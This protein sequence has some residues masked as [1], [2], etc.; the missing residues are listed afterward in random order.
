MN[1]RS[2]WLLV[3]V[4]SF[5]MV[6]SVIPAFAETLPELQDNE[7]SSESE[8][9]EYGKNDFNSTSFSEPDFSNNQQDE[10]KT[11]EESYI[12]EGDLDKS[13]DEEIDKSQRTTDESANDEPASNDESVSNEVKESPAISIVDEIGNENEFTAI[14]K[15]YSTDNKRVKAAVW[16]DINGQ[17]DLKWY[18]CEF[19]NDH[20]IA[21]IPVINHRA[22][23]KYYVHFYDENNMRF[24]AASE[25]NVSKPGCSR[26]TAE[27]IDKKTGSFDIIIENPESVSGIKNIRVAVWSS[28]DCSDLKWYNAAVENDNYRVKVNISDHEYNLRKY[29]AHIY[30]ES[31]NGILSFIGAVDNIDMSAEGTVEIKE[32]SDTYTINIKEIAALNNDIDSIKC[33]VW[34]NINGQDD[35]KWVEGSFEVSSDSASISYK[36]SMFKDFGGYSVHV[37][38]KTKTGKMFFIKALQYEIEMPVVESID[39]NVTMDTGS[40]SIKLT[41]LSNDNNIK[42]ILVPVWSKPD[43]SNIIWYK[44]KKNSDG[45]YE[46]GSNILKH[47]NTLEKYNIHVYLRDMNDA[48]HFMG[49]TN[50]DFTPKCEGILVESKEENVRYEVSVNGLSLPK[51]NAYTV[52]F[53]VWSEQNG[54]DDLKWYDAIS[55][56][57]K[58]IS[59][60]DIRNHKTTGRYIVHAY[61]A[62]GN[63]KIFLTGT[64]Q[65]EVAEP[66]T[67]T[68]IKITNINENNGYFDVEVR[69]TDTSSDVKDVI[70][71]VW[72]ME[73]QG[74][75]YFYTAVRQE[76]GIYGF[77]VYLSNHKQMLGNY[78]LHVYCKYANGIMKFSNAAN[79]NINP[80]N[81]ISVQGNTVNGR[82]TVSLKNLSTEYSDVRFA[83]WSKN[84]GQDDLRWYTAKK[85]NNTWNSVVDYINHKTSGLYYVHAYAN[86][87]FLCATEFYFN[88]NNKFETWSDNYLAHAMGAI[89]GN[90][91]TGTLEAFENAYANGIRTFEVDLIFTLDNRIVLKHDWSQYTCKDFLPGYVPTYEEFMNA[92]VLDKYTPLSFE[93][94]CFL[95]KKYPDIWIVTDTKDSSVKKVNEKFSEMY[96]TANRINA[97]PVLDRMVVQIYNQDMKKNVESIHPFKNYIFTMY[98][99]WD[100][101]DMNAFESYCKW[102][103]NNNVNSICMWYWYENDN[104]LSITNKYGLNLYLHTLNDKNKAD[105]YLKKGVAEI[106][107]DT[108]F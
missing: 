97:L 34:S 36:K 8:Y 79:C 104:I 68:E 16:S 60:I 45:T 42:E 107:T 4:L 96:N 69:I 56:D 26:I 70:V 53:A 5:T 32:N 82:K 48:L 11:V 47:K 98:Q 24:I 38:A 80:I 41:G 61:L 25:F 6:F 2:K 102:S 51:N 40:F 66:K 72:S 90:A 3:V 94:L 108:L 21:R 84:K 93:D 103:M 12:E 9:T 10:E 87:R 91:Y 49:C 63:D 13:D 31:N 14:L 54:Q 52:K 43:Q 35:L 17:D 7:T 62:K 77:R 29:S 71:P 58:Y 85:D 65:L 46:I 88:S 50:M 20:Y 106:Y 75:I 67:D 64:S 27:N 81:Y 59:T 44:A 28:K 100:G 101:N 18:G 1:L 23:G 83:V 78:N 57:N 74:N 76:E 55:S 92:N 39:T 73:N 95:M 89:D 19:I 86:G 15:N 30:L 22:L 33:A 105:Y 99:L 37:Y